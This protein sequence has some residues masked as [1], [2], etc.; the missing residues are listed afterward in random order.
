MSRRFIS[1]RGWAILSFSISGLLL[2]SALLLY[3]GS[4]T[5]FS[6]VNAS[7]V[8]AGI[9]KAP[10]ISTGLRR[11]LTYEQWVAL[12]RQEAKVA[13]EKQPQRLMVLAGDSLSLWFPPELL[14]PE[15]SWLN[16]GISGETSAGLLRRL[17]LFDRTQPEVV[18]VMIGIND[19]LRGVDAETVLANHREIVS[20]L[21][22]AHPQAQIVVQSLL[23]HGDRR[24][25]RSQLSSDEAALQR[26]PSASLPRQALVLNSDI[27]QLNQALA[28]MAKAEGVDYLDLQPYFTDANGALVADLSTDG[29]HLSAEGY[30]VWRSRLQLFMQQ[31]KAKRRSR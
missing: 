1:P 22:A 2:L 4:P 17:K 13:A 10:S 29:L 25:S 18:F 9:A 24:L 19:L 6:Q 3:R 5:A 11:Q 16:Q 7:T 26:Q 30:Q 12:L 14:P 15:E 23:P 20:Y 27:R 28:E 8:Q 21:K 31:Q